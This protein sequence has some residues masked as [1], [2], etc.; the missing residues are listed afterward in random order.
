MVAEAADR[1]RDIIAAVN[2][3]GSWEGVS[4]KNKWDSYLML[5]YCYYQMDE[6]LVPDHLF[7][8]LCKKLE[9]NP[10][11]IGSHLYDESLISAGSG[12]SFISKLP[13]VVADIATFLCKEKHHGRR[14]NKRPHL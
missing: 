14:T 9:Y 2:V 12:F 13:P 8:S 3:A 4:P 6:S 10:L 11:F 1:Y 7:D 5:S